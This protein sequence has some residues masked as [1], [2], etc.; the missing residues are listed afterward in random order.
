MIEKHK[1][2]DKIINFKENKAEC[3]YNCKHCY[4]IDNYYNCFIG[5][6]Q[7]NIKFSL[8][9]EIMGF[10][11]TPGSVCDSFSLRRIDKIKQA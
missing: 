11:V 4:K 3:C 6:T 1:I 2:T 7:S 5:E 8:L 10:T 9:Y